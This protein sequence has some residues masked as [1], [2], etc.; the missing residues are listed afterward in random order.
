VQ[1][2]FLICSD[3]EGAKKWLIEQEVVEATDG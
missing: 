1:E 2:V 3:S